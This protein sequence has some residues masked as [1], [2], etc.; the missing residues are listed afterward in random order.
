MPD[1]RVEVE[2]DPVPTTNL[3][4]N[5]NG[6]LGGWGWLTPVAGSFMAGGVNLH[7][8]HGS[9]TSELVYTGPAN[10]PN[11]F[12]TEPI[13]VTPGKYVNATWQYVATVALFH[14]AV[15]E[16]LK[17]DGTLQSSTGQTGYFGTG[18]HSLVVPVVVPA[19]AAYVRLR[20]DLYQNT[21]G[22]NPTSGPDTHLKKV[23]LAQGTQLQVAGLVYSDP[24]VWQD[25]TGPTLQLQVDRAA[26]DAGTLSGTIRD[27][28]LDPAVADDLRPGRRC[29]LMAKGVLTDYRPVIVTKLLRAEAK[30]DKRKT[31][32]AGN[33]RTTITVAGADNAQALANT[34][35]PRGVAT[36]AELPYLL[37]GAGV[38][39]SVNGSG[40]QVLAGTVVSTNDNASLLDQVAVT[41]DT[42]RAYAYVNS[43]GVLVVTDAP[44]ASG[45][46]F[47]D[48]DES[49]SYT[50]IDVGFATDE[51]IN[52]VKINWLR[53]DATTGKTEQVAYGP[54]E[55]ATS[56]DTWGI[57]SR[58]FTIH[59]AA[60]NP[61]TI[62]TYANAVLAAN[63]TPVRKVRTLTVNVESP[64][65]VDAVLNAELTNTVTID[66]A[67]QQF[68]ARVASVSHKIT[69]KRWTAV[70]TFDQET[71]VAQPTVI[72]RPLD[73][74]GA[75]LAEGVGFTIAPTY[76]GGDPPNGTTGV[77]FTCRGG[78][79]RGVISGTAYTVN[80]SVGI[81]LRAYIDGVQVGACYMQPSLPQNV[82]LQLPPIA[83]TKTVTPGT[84]YL[85]M[86]LEAGS[87]TGG[88]E[89]LSMFGI[90]TDA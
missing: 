56:I 64:E 60:E 18:T 1:L 67:G 11:W 14:R 85:Y 2:A 34:P 26:L 48:D 7:P 36:V 78:V 63:K 28:T 83:F 61:A 9:G 38:P 22:G 12:T 19:T 13:P 53:Y 27:A 31:D 72:P 87:W 80:G 6:E 90:V 54:Y 71:T 46:G 50:G 65:L 20:F 41:R 47:A 70:F 88:G 24:Y 79:L 37:E 42:A 45:V 23:A 86:K 68:T 30:Y 43:A 44:A 35:E 32:A 10:V 8:L 58:T 49:R 39:W 29:R 21:A 82:R 76:N 57:H 89:V 51:C 84:H 81:V 5:P 15:L 4:E 52:S 77:A 17:A 73:A 74:S 3:V 69:A 40:K 59:G 75:V 33:V 55:D 16:F 66:F 25:V 62:A